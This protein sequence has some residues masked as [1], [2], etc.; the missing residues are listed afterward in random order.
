MTHKEESAAAVGGCELLAQA[1]GRRCVSSPGGCTSKDCV[2][3]CQQQ[4]QVKRGGV[5][6]RMGQRCGALRRASCKRFMQAL[7]NRASHKFSSGRAPP[8][9][10]LACSTAHDCLWC[11]PA[12]VPLAGHTHKSL[13][14]WVAWTP[15][16]LLRLRCK[17]PGGCKQSQSSR[18]P[19]L[20]LPA[21]MS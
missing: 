4:A 5:G 18:S 3:R 11:L 15:I 10:S 16:S 17:R 6:E 7:H 9:C 13:G 1:A 19:S 12:G 14:S 2:C 20:P 8:S 21:A